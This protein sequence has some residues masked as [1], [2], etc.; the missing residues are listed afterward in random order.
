MKGKPHVGQ[1]G[2]VQFTVETKHT[3]DFADDRMPAVLSTPCLVGFL[4]QAG[5]EA[6][7]PWLEDG[8]NSVGMEIDVKHVA[9]TP[10]GHTVTCVARVI[11]VDGAIVDFQVEASDETE[12]I[13]RGLH[14]RA[15]IRMDRFAR[16]VEKKRVR[17]D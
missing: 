9:P 8:E 10:I 5:R 11:H 16:R 1:T 6:L 13:A 7:Q 14:K 3:I 15:I 4:E 2:Q 17:S 12:R